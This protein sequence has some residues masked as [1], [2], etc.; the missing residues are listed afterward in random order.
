MPMNV[1]QAQLLFTCHGLLVTLLVGLGKKSRRKA[2][3]L[4]PVCNEQN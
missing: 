4:A 3:F 1:G 2:A